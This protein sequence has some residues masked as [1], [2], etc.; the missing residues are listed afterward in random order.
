MNPIEQT[1]LVW[2]RGQICRPIAI[3]PKGVIIRT[4][5]TALVSGQKIREIIRWHQ[6]EEC[7]LNKW[8][9]TLSWSWEIHFKTVHHSLHADEMLNRQRSIQRG[10]DFVKEKY[11]IL[12]YLDNGK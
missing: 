5:R 11:N 9:D 2:H 1:A 12:S 6:L 10:L 7:D 3:L 8:S 4:N